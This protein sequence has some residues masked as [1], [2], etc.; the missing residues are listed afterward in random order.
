[1][2][3]FRYTALTLSMMCFL[4]VHL[5]AENIRHIPK[6]VYLS[7][8]NVLINKNSILIKTNK[9][10]IKVKVIRSDAKGLYVL[11]Q[12]LLSAKG[13]P[14]VAF[15]AAYTCPHC[16]RVF[17]SERALRNHNCPLKDFPPRQ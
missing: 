2:K 5:N 12:E 16:Y 7:E 17:S 8:Q 14:S 3:I 9:G 6:K 11:A 1:M 4:F 15:K 13:T 10:P